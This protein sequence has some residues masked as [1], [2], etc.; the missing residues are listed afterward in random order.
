MVK[1][2]AV[3]DPDLRAPAAAVALVDFQQVTTPC[4]LNTRRPHQSRT[5]HPLFTPHIHTNQNAPA[6][7]VVLVE[8]Q[9]ARVSLPT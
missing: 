6:A 7:A 9:Q 1:R 5:P 3:G 4:S 8:F 2:D